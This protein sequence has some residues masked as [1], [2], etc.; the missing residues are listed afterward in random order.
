MEQADVE[1][2]SAPAGRGS[3]GSGMGSDGDDTRLQCE[4][5]LPAEE[6]V[7][8]KTDAPGVSP[9]LPSP[10]IKPEQHLGWKVAF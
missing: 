8:T 4:E 7:A 6:A 3:G 10:Q 9:S 1:K 2:T 5:A